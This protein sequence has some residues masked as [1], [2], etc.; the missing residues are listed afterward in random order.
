MS[1]Q[2]KIQIPNPQL[3]D[4]TSTPEYVPS[5]I[6]N[7]PKPILKRSSNQYIDN[8]LSPNINN[9]NNFREIR[10]SLGNK[11]KLTKEILFTFNKDEDLKDYPISN[12]G[13][14][15]ECD[16]FVKNKHTFFIIYIFILNLFI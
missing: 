7:P 4:D 14:S 9:N 8:K 1:K 13:V 5:P 11:D 12:E 15:R 6:D 10:I 16:G 2:L 3:L